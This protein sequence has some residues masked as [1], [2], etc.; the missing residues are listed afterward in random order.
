MNVTVLLVIHNAEMY[1]E[2]C[3]NSVLLQS[4]KDFELLIFSR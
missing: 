2:E 3:I 4:L 1:I